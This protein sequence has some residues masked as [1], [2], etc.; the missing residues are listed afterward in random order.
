MKDIGTGLVANL[1]LLTEFSRS[2]EATAEWWNHVKA[3]LESPNPTLLPLEI[4]SGDAREKFSRWTELQQGF[5]QYYNIVR[6]YFCWTDS[7]PIGRASDIHH[8]PPG[9]LGTRALPR[10][11]RIFQHGLEGRRVCT[12]CSTELRGA[13]HGPRPPA[14]RNN[15][16]YHSSFQEISRY[17]S[18]LWIPRV[19]EEGQ[20]RATQRPGHP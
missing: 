2:V 11:P 19:F 8:I 12:Q 4:K 5:Q 20:R 18:D 6:L 17:E 3:D 10:T 7:S 9:E 1:N 14:S 13:L 15:N 16:R